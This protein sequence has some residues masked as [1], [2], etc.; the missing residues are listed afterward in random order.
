MDVEILEPADTDYHDSRRGEI[1][2][3]SWKGSEGEKKW[4][5]ILWTKINLFS[6]DYACNVRSPMGKE[7][8]VRFTKKTVKHGAAT[9]WCM[10]GF[11]GMALVR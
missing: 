3:I 11:L 5:N 9:S 6:N 2:H 7:C 4:R 1:D 10:E 8:H